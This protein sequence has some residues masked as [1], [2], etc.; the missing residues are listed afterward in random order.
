MAEAWN[1]LR[2]LLRLRMVFR[3]GRKS[4]SLQQ[5]PPQPVIPRR[6]QRR[7]K[8]PPA[9]TVTPSSASRI[10]STGSG[11]V[12]R[13]PCNPVQIVESNVSVCKLDE[14]SAN[15]AAPK[16]K[17][18]PSQEEITFAASCLGRRQRDQRSRW[19][20]WID[21]VHAYRNMEIVLPTGERAFVYGALRGKVVWTF[22]DNGLAG[23][24][25]GAGVSWGVLPANLVRILRNRDAQLLG[26]LKAGVRERPS[27]AKAQAARANGKRPCRP[28]RRRGR[29]R[30]SANQTSA[31]ALAVIRSRIITNFVR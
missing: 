11:T 29:P 30:K 22:G 8:R 16:A 12:T 6:R 10:A 9:P 3:V 25:D 23:G 2:R 5:P 1:S 14:S 21:D 28:G 19:T 17:S 4:V 15:Q 27:E 18:V 26:A 7:A 31:S 13:T 20:G 24:I